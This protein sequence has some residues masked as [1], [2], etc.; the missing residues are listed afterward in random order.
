MRTHGAHSERVVAPLAQAHAR[1]LLRQRGLRAGDLSAVGHGLLRN[2][3]RA[4]AALELLDRHAAEVGLLDG[5]GEPRGFTRLYVQLLNSERH[6][7]RALEQHVQLERREPSMVAI[8][9]GQ[10]RHVNGDD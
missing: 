9:A 3:S 7:L 1:R 4:A 5:D 8:L 10:A 6:A 2:W